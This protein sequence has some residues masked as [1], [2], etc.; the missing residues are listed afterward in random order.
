M[1]GQRRTAMFKLNGARPQDLPI[2]RLLQYMRAFADLVGSTEKVRI[3]N[4]SPGSVKFGLD[5]EPSHYPTLVERIATAQNPSRASASVTKAVH[6]LEEM[7]TE[8]GM[9][10]EFRA[11]STRLLYLRGY[12]R[13]GG[14]IVGPVVQRYVVRGQ[15]IGLEGK[16]ATKHVRLLEYGTKRELRGDFRSEDLGRL[17][18]QHLWGGIVELSGVARMSRYPDGRWEVQSFHLDE[19]RELEPSNVSDVM[20]GLREIFA[21]EA[22][23]RTAA[24]L[25]GK[26]RS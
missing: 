11:G 6:W 7:I 20:R 16:D 8:D 14:P 18:I 19:V 17:L 5:V 10:A 3:R 23:G 26:L 21:D 15:I 9:T 12:T 25:V 4:L 1:S 24:A 2:E 22:T 13:R